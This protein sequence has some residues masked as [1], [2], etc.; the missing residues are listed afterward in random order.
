MAIQRFSL[1]RNFRG[2]DRSQ[3]IVGPQF[4][5]SCTNCRSAAHI[6]GLLGPRMA[7][8]RA[9]VKTY[10]LLGAG[11][12]AAAFGHFLI[13][14]NNQGSWAGDGIAWPGLTTPTTVTPITGMDTSARMRTLQFK[15][16]AFA[17]NGRNRMRCM[18][19]LGWTFAGIKKT[20]DVAP[21]V[22]T[23]GVGLTGDYYYYVVPANTNKLN[24]Y[25]RPVEGLPLP[26]TAKITLAN[27]GVRIT[28]IPATHAD[29]QVNFWNIYRT[30]ADT[31]DTDI[32]DDLQEFFYVGQVA[33]G[34]TT[35]DDTTADT[36]LNDA[37]R[38]RFRTNIPP[39]FKF[40]AVYGN[41]VFGAGFDPIKT[42][43]VTRL[44]AISLVLV[45]GANVATIA[46][47]ANG[48]TVGQSVTIS[49]LT[50]ADAFYNGTHTITV[51]ATDGFSFA[52]VHA[53][54]AVHVPAGTG[55]ADSVTPYV[56]FTTALP[57]GAL[58][59]WF[60]KDGD[61]KRYRIT[62][63]NGSI[64]TLA[65][66][67]VSTDLGFTGAAGALT[68]ANYN[69]FREP[70]E[71]YCSEFEDAEAWGL[72]GEGYRNT[73]VVPGHQAVTAL[74]PYQGVL[75]VFT[76]DAIYAISGQGQNREDYKILPD[77]L[78]RGYGAVSC[79][80]VC[81]VEQECHFLSLRG[82]VRLTGGAPDPYGARLNT[83]WLDTLTSDQLAVATMGTDDDSI[84]IGIP[85]F[86]LGAGTENSLVWR[87]DRQEQFWDYETEM[88]PK[89]F[90]RFDGENGDVNRLFY[91]QDRFICK[92][93][94]GS[95][96]S[97]T[98][99]ATDPIDLI[100]AVTSGS[101]Y[102]TQAGTAVFNSSRLLFS[103]QLT[104]NIATIVT[105][106]AHGFSA[107]ETIDV[108]AFD[109]NY[110]GTFVILTVP[111]TTSFTYAKVHANI[112]I[113]TAP[114]PSAVYG[115]WYT[116]QFQ[117]TNG[118]C[119]QAYIRFYRAGLLIGTRR[120]VSQA[121]A[122]YVVWSSTATDVGSGTLDLAVGDTFTIGNVIW[123]YV[124][125]AFDAGAPAQRKQIVDL[126]IHFGVVD[127]ARSVIVTH[128][129]DFVYNTA[130]P[131]TK[132]STE[133]VGSIFENTSCFLYAALLESRNGA[134]L[135]DVSVRAEVAESVV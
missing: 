102:H 7:R 17:F 56:S 20:A 11:I 3:Y 127:S 43:T 79:D 99:A 45:N 101:V 124:T 121:G 72:D 55:F 131:I 54:D 122:Q 21:T 90:V 2:I 35:F 63:V 66:V 58:G 25:G 48:F 109:A 38:L 1:A 71:I 30:K 87:F 120:I 15:N 123:N 37:F 96:G 52:L 74:M 113:E 98:G 83:D 112:A 28:V 106:V 108:N 73:F 29:S 94:S 95:T 133:I 50:G 115:A 125:T 13:T 67:G 57:D 110:N 80:A 19:G 84:F 12:L 8:S 51:V 77:P 89:A 22:A 100:T 49:G 44:K 82:P 128:F 46:C 64:A 132:A 26:R 6:L 134:V 31:L 116:T 88:C 10:P 14:A 93:K 61:S 40:G 76:I 41:R 42:G 105:T 9:F 97:T 62:N 85:Y 59:C 5:R 24:T 75:L 135:Y 91:L 33:I 103:T 65:A 60:K 86:V 4:T 104:A 111:T 70:S 130:N 117:T 23:N 129:K 16:R 81:M 32:S 53:L 68:A 18:D 34:T 36:S 47:A 92:P 118:G 107:G 78:Y 27:Q 126:D 69:V 119:E 114:Y 39:T